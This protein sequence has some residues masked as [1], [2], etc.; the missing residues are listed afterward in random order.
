LVQVRDPQTANSPP[1]SVKGS[2]W[3]KEL[4]KNEMKSRKAKIHN[5]G[6]NKK[7]I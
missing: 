3:K 6:P 2:V 4:F 1:K 5:I 7:I